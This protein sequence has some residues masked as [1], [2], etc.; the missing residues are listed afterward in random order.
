LHSSLVQTRKIGKTKKDIRDAIRWNNIDTAVA[1]NLAFFVNAAILVVA[2]AVFYR[3]GYFEIAEIQD[4]H[5]LLAP[6]LGAS[7]A[8]FAFA[9]ALLASGQSST[10]TGTLAGQIVM[11][12]YLNLRIPAWLRRIITRLLA[13]IPAVLVISHYGEHSTSA[14]LVLSQVVLSLQLPFAI[15]PLIHAVADKKR[16]GEFSI[17]P[18]IQTLA[19][20]VAAIIVGLNVKLV[21]D[22]IGG[23]LDAAGDNAWLLRLTVIPLAALVALLLVYVTLQPWLRNRS[24]IMASRRTAGVHQDVVLSTPVLVKPDPYKH[25]AVALDFSGNEDKLLSE[26]LRVIDKGQTHVTLMH[27]VES[28]VARSLGNEVEDFETFADTDKLEKLAGMMKNTGVA[29]DWQ[30]GA[31]EPASELALMVNNLNVDMVILGSHG[32][33]GVSDLIHGTVISNL[34]HHVKASVMIIPLGS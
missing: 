2:A 4:A 21:A 27:V 15:I 5:R 11:E 34:R 19:W 23:W 29:A 10:I 9:I 13:I 33:S 8:P 32:H 17:A 24:A 1:L 18:W 6:I 3:N 12:G 22:Q 31:G 7:I 20:I 25:V 30:L 14:M 28:P 26:T 16:M